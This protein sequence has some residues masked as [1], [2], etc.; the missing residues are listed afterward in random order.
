MLDTR[1]PHS[2]MAVTSY[3]DVFYDSSRTP[4]QRL[5]GKSKERQQLEEATLNVHISL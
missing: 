2:Q 3:S 4:L 1:D 5:R